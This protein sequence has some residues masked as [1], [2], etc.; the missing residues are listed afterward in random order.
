ML[1]KF[2]NTKLSA[3]VLLEGRKDPQRDLDRQD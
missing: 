1:S 2:T 3:N